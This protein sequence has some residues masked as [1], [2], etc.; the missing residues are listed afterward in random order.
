MKKV[1]FYNLG[2]SII[3]VLIAL[4]ILGVLVAAVLVFLQRETFFQKQISTKESYHEV[5]NSIKL[6][7]G[8]EIRTILIA[9]N[10][11]SLEGKSVRIGSDLSLKF[12]KDLKIPT[13]Q[14]IHAATEFMKKASEMCKKP[15]FFK[16]GTSFCMQIEKT[17]PKD[18]EGKKKGGYLF[19]NFEYA[20]VIFTVIVEHTSG[21]TQTP[22]E[23]GK[24][25]SAT[26][27]EVYI[28]IAWTYK[29]PEG[30]PR[31]SHDE[32]SSFFLSPE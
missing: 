23:F 9:G 27:A 21:L 16:S 32:V 24:T 13:N 17:N 6:V 10:G 20:F 7:M 18:L 28:H 5:L 25:G 22:N 30:V 4:A 2:F 8:K 3:S 1:K 11:K 29:T 31:I 19:K 26:L 12:T 15:F 14:G